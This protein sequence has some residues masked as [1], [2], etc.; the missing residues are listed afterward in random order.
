MKLQFAVITLFVLGAA[1]FGQGSATLGYASPGD[2]GL[3][4]NYE[5]ISWGGSDN[6]YAQGTDNNSL[7]GIA[8]NGT[9]VGL[10]ISVPAAA[11]SPVT[12]SAYAFADNTIDAQYGSYTGEQYLIVSQTKPS[13]FIRKYGWAGYYGFDG[14]EFLGDY[15]YLTAELP[16]QNSSK[17]V[18]NRTTA[19]VAIQSQTRT[20]T[21][22]K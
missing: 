19:G 14:Y 12:G 21:I 1:A 13:K 20:K 16:G 5:Q 18:L 17:P 3:Y 11:Q 10:K 7:C 15:G 9:M 6:F 4:C 22:T 8:N 2:V